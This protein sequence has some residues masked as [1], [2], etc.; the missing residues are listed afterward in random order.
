VAACFAVT[1]LLGPLL[2]GWQRWVAAAS[3]VA[4]LQKLAQ[5]SDA[6]PDTVGRLGP[7]PSLWLVCGYAL[8]ALAGAA[9]VFRRRGA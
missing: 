3:P 5:S 1:G 4:A 9:A 7:W 2:G 8:V 6:A